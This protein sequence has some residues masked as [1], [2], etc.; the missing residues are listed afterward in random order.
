[1]NDQG[2]PEPTAAAASDDTAPASGAGAAATSSGSGTH[3]APAV[4]RRCG[5]PLTPGQLALPLLGTPKFGVRL[6]SLSVEADVAAG[7]C[8]ECGLLELWVPDTAKL[9]KAIRADRL[10]HE[11]VKKLPGR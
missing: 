3:A 5:G 10:V 2:T 1:M 6:G 11:R 7:L 4:C 9:Q 8:L